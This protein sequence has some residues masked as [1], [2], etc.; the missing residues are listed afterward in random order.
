MH[1]LCP[2]S[3]KME[4]RLGNEI[5]SCQSHIYLKLKI[6]L[7][8]G[9]VEQW[10]KE[11]IRIYHRKLRSSYIE[12]SLDER[13]THYKPE[14]NEGRYYCRFKFLYSCVCPVHRQQRIK[15]PKFYVICQENI[16]S[17]CSEMPTLTIKESVEPPNDTR[18]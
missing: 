5:S 11:T 13:P 7:L 14:V 17:C 8:S 6:I 2:K 9:R 3:S 4:K 1:P 16:Y 10:I 18:C 15:T 12:L